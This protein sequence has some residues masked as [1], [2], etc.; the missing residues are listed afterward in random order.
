M[1]IWG[2]LI[3]CGGSIIT[4]LITA[5]ATIMAAQIVKKGNEKNQTRTPID[6]SPSLPPKITPKSQN[7][8]GKTNS[9]G[10]QRALVLGIISILIVL[11]TSCTIL[12]LSSQ[13]MEPPELL[14]FSSIALI[15]G[16]I[17]VLSKK[18]WATTTALILS[19]LLFFTQ[20]TIGLY[21]AV[22][23]IFNLP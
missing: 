5:I 13:N 20:L 10:K 21:W 9:L 12:G 7:E 14:C 1:E 17:A 2:A 6:P 19:G 16:A 18:K 22:L 15:F 3:S 8:V 4:A 11:M 23:F